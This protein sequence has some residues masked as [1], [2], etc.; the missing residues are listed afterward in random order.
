MSKFL[1]LCGALLC[2][3]LSASAQDSTAAF[4]ASSPAGEPPAPASLSPVNREPWQLGL[5][6]QYQHHNAYAGFHTVGYNVDLTRY[7]NE[8]FGIEGT[9]VFGFGSTADT[10][11]ITAKSL[12]IGGG[13][14]IAIGNNA[15]FE[16]FVHVLAGWERLRFAQTGKLGVDS[17]PTFY[18]GGG[19][20]YKFG[21][22]ASWRVQGDFVGSHFGHTINKNYS[23]GTG[24]IFNF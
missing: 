7:V 22:R 12:F 16:P 8:W 17:A 4:D 13:P 10:P 24:F 9:G 18:G 11:S 2:I 6:F 19:V 21:G 15:R 3:S 20:D 5:G 1:V 23:F 14:H